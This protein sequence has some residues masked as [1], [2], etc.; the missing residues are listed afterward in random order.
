MWSRLRAGRVASGVR[1]AFDGGAPNTLRVIQHVNQ[2]LRTIGE[3]PLTSP[4]IARIRRLADARTAFEGL[5]QP[6]N[7]PAD[8]VP[9]APA[10]DANADNSS[11]EALIPERGQPQPTPDPSHTETGLSYGSTASIDY[12]SQAAAPSAPQDQTA[13]PAV[14]DQ[15]G[16]LDVTQASE[17]QQGTALPQTQAAASIEGET[18]TAQ[19]TAAPDVSAQFSRGAASDQTQSD[20]FKAWYGEW[21]NAGHVQEQLE[22]YGARARTPQDGG[23]SSVHGL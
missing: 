4:E 5:N 9:A 14:S 15:P 1:N 8:R 17:T 18:Q 2:G 16:G 22:S 7:L 23:N 11:M 19:S 10:V 13:S 12:E 20:A 3:Q 21:Q 6:A